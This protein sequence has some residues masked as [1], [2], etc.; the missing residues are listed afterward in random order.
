MAIQRVGCMVDNVPRRIGSSNV[1]AVLCICLAVGTHRSFIVTA[2]LRHIS[3]WHMKH[4]RL[5]FLRRQ[6][7]QALA[8]LRLGVA[9]SIVLKGQ[10]VPRAKRTDRTGHF[11]RG[12]SP[13]VPHISP[14]ISVF[15][16]YK[17][18]QSHFSPKR[19]IFAISYIMAELVT[20]PE[21]SKA[22]K[23]QRV[24]EHARKDTSASPAQVHTPQWVS[25]VAGGIA[26]GV[27]AAI[28][29]SILPFAILYSTNFIQYPFEYSK[30]RVQLL[31]N[32]AIR[33]SNPLRL[34]FQVAKQESVGGLYTGCSTLVIVRP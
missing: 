4:C 18:S 6:N 34:I 5:T 25:L 19:L 27:E 23:P 32:S 11:L 15:E 7:T 33:T 20:T 31:D 17:E 16:L 30:T 22:K 1:G 24:G 13:S 2:E 8:A 3:P 29:V 26:G 28:T 14:Q 12:K 9:L 10:V 21:Q